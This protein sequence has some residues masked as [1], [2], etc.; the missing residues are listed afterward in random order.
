L[1]ETDGGWQ[2]V[3]PGAIP[4]RDGDPAPHALSV[5]EIHAIADAFRASARRALEAGFQIVEIHGAH[6]YLIHQFLSPLSNRRDDDY[7]GPL[8][9]RLRLALEVAEAVRREWPAHLPLL[10]RA[11]ATDWV[12]GGWTLEETIELSRRLHGL[13]VDLIDCSSGGSSPRAKIPIGPGY[14]VAFADRIR[15]EAGIP[16]AAVGMIT[17]PEQAN[18]IIAAGHADLVL[19]AREFL[20]N[21]YFPLTAGAPPPVQY[22]RAW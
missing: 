12:D 11:S 18:A 1:A 16:T 6:G 10:F 9:N 3:A 22:A 7:G 4:F 2:T 5:P 14:Q 13:G 19:L 20:R 15:R 8:E 21:P 17:T